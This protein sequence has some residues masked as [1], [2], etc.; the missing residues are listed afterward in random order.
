M[1]GFG[2][3]SAAG[4]GVALTGVRIVAS[5]TG[6][7]H[8]TLV[9]QLFVNREAVAIEA[10]YTFPLPDGAAVCGFEAVTGDRVLTGVMEELE[11]GLEKY[12]EAVRAGE[13]AFIAEMWRPDVF[14]T[15][16][17]N[18]KP[19]QAVLI[20][21][22]YVAEAALADR[23]L[24]LSFPLTIAP[25]YGTATG[26]NDLVTAAVESDALNP[27][28]VLAVPYGLDFSATL[29]VGAR[30]RSV[31]SPSHGVTVE[32][33]EGSGAWKV[34]LAGNGALMN[35]DLVL[36][37]QLSHEPAASARLEAGPAEDEQFIA[38]DFV[39]TFEDEELEERTHSREVVFVLDCS[40]SME[41]PSIEQARLALA[42][43]LKSLSE[44]DRFNIC[45]FGSTHQ[46][47]FPAAEVYGQGTLDRALAYLAETG[48]N[49]GGT[50]LYAPLAEAMTLSDKPSAAAP[51]VRDVV[52]LTDGQVS[53][54][55]AIVE[56]A[57]R[58][59]GRVRLFTFGIGS[60]PSAFLIN[61]LARAT[62]GAS[63][64]I[65]EGER[66]EEKVLRTFARMN[67]PRLESLSVDFNTGHAVL[68]PRE[69]PALF[70]GDFASLTARVIGRT[71]PHTVTVSGRLG[72]KVKRWTVPVFASAGGVGSTEAAKV[73]VIGARWVRSRMV[74]LETEGLDSER[75]GSI[76]SLSKTYGVLCKET[77]LVAVEHRSLA[78]RTSGMPALRRVPVMLAQGWGGVNALMD[79][80]KTGFAMP[81]QPAPMCPPCTAAPGG[82]AAFSMEFSAAPKKAREHLHRDDSVRRIPSIDRR[83]AQ[84]YEPQQPEG[85]DELA[86]LL[87]RQ[88]A[89]G[90]FATGL[91]HQKTLNGKAFD[92]PSLAKELAAQ[93]VSGPALATALTLAALALCFA[94]QADLWRPAFK[95]GLRWLAK[96]AP[97]AKAWV[98]EKTGDAVA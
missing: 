20:R 84:N 65:A 72:D 80:A 6:S 4:N 91:L 45:R 82:A 33:G 78:E 62:R 2:M 29:D 35:R 93:G 30:I 17:G 54:E 31:G 66:I 38:V 70:D 63:E 27:P 97:S 25:R 94:D 76:V 8:R 58:H 61:G 74:E 47:M 60:A 36:E 79:S 46:W 22:T 44:G 34:R 16:I 23:V 57:R 32:A 26:T 42:L 51:A 56:L 39:P 69:L 81:A 19:G 77:T 90:D 89:A 15:R 14:S 9:E 1:E 49:L 21:L 24:R 64:F 18:V 48:A 43:C 98:D 28:H 83:A 41:G 59:K 13:G 88:T 75:K 92:G 11:A 68:A 67:S 3:F 12:E 5:V 55:P 53:N 86:N 87:L 52:L 50:E 71:P 96:H 40:G 73:G 10:V 37:V 95:K 85:V 7:G